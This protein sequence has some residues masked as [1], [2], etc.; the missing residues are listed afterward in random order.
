MLSVRAKVPILTGFATDEGTQFVNPY[1]NSS[2]A[3]NQLFT[4]LIP[5]FNQTDLQLLNKLYPDPETDPSSPYLENRGLGLGSQYKRAATAYGH[6]AYVC[7]VFTTANHAS[8]EVPVWVWHWATSVSR[9]LG[10]AH[11][12]HTP[13]E[14]NEEYIRSISDTQKELA[15]DVAGYMT[16]FITSGD[17][18]AV[19]SSLGKNRP[20]W[21]KYNTA[22]EGA[23]MVL[24]DG[25]DE[26]AGG[27]NKGV[28]AAM[29]VNNRF[30][31]ECQFWNSR[32]DKLSR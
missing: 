22:D 21:K 1:I 30:T 19:R 28:V 5:D 4:T 31:D 17:P 29:G 8:K 20:E 14:S 15:A 2:D 10:A 26:R 18:N 13:Y 23:L 25:N 9:V 16:S 3:F 7:N 12:S 6:Y 24:G 27:T 32:V 11:T